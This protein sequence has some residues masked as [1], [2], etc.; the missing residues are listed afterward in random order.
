MPVR[1]ARVEAVPLDARLKTPFR[2]RNVVRTTSTNVLV[3]IVDEDG[4]VGYGEACPVPQL[5]AETQESVV[6]LIE[7]LAASELVGQYA[8]HW[9]PL[10][11]RVGTR[12]FQATFTLA[13]V[14]MALLDLAGKALGIPVHEL[15]GGR[16]RDEIELH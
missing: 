15:L 3:R 7:Q 16:F 2:F 13:A 12:L 9:R 4:R 10:M 5:T 6:A 8:R 1:I 11:S 14:E